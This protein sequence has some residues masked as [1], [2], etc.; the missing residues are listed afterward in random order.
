MD[1]PTQASESS[2]AVT[3]HRLHTA[4]GGTPAL[5]LLQSLTSEDPRPGS[6]LPLPS[7]RSGDHLPGPP[8]GSQGAK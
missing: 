8:S 3:A 7:Q 5:C 6:L 2:E 4:G 1:S